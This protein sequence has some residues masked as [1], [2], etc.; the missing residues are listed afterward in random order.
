MDRPTEEMIVSGVGALA[1]LGVGF[2]LL[3]GGV[4]RAF[5]LLG[6]THRTVVPVFFM[7]AGSVATRLLFLDWRESVVR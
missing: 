4:S 6:Y 7:L 2:L 1:G 3:E 5:T